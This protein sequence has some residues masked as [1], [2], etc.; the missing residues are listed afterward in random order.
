MSIL[1]AGTKII[2]QNIGSGLNCRFT[3]AAQTLTKQLNKIAIRETKSDKIIYTFSKAVP[4]DLKR[5]TSKSIEDSYKRVT[6]TNPKDNKVYHILE[7]GREKG[8]V[9]VRILDKDGAF[10]KNAELE[11]KNIVIFDNFFS[12]RGITHGEMM[13][14]FVKRFNPFANVERLEHKK[15]WIE[16]IRY[17]GELPMHLEL[18][19]F[20]ELE[21][22]M[23]NGKK[24][25]YISISEANTINCGHVIG[26]KGTVQ[27]DYVHSSPYIR[28]IEPV[29][30][31]IMSKGTR[32]FEAAGNDSKFAPIMVSDRLA[33]GG[34]EGVGSLVKGKIA[35]NSCS[36]NS[37]FTQHYERNNYLPKLVKDDNGKVVG[38]NVTG[39][40]GVD[41]PINYKTKKMSGVR[42]G[43]SYAVPVRVAKLALNEML[44][45]IL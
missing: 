27:N 3:R 44:E 20:Q 17:R 35:K 37:I 21:Q 42:G 36:R 4:E 39:L 16:N 33:I 6:W 45:G 29:F 28:D 10:V 9:Q 26:Q 15:G 41:M 25:D 38:I 14:V 31:D 43:T 30:K 7:E 1:S 24:V 23:K 12:P 34:V 5:L 32:I 19:R 22:Q 40:S 11:P 13:E 2:E 8:K 18:K